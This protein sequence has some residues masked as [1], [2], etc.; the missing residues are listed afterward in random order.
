VRLMRQRIEEA[1]QFGGAVHS[2]HDQI[3][4]M[5]HGAVR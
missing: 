4:G 5:R 1:P 2:R 3:E